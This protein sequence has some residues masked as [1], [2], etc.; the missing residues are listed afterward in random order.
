MRVAHYFN[1]K[2]LKIVRF[3]SRIAGSLTWLVKSAIAL[4]FRAKREIQDK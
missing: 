2:P 4:L 1:T 3:F